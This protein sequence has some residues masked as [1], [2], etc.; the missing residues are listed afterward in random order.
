MEKRQ[1]HRIAYLTARRRLLCVRSRALR[2]EKLLTIFLPFHLM[3]EAK[4]FYSPR[5]KGAL[6]QESIAPEKA[7][8]AHSFFRFY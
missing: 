5:Q 7:I 1:L 2:C 6:P 3:L 8:F 4:A